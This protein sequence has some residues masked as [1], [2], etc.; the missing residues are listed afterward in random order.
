MQS[1]SYRC[2]GCQDIIGSILA[3]LPTASRSKFE[4][5]PHLI[6]AST[7]YSSP[8]GLRFMDHLESYLK[9]LSLLLVFSSLPSRHAFQTMIQ[10]AYRESNEKVLLPLLDAFSFY[11]C[12][13]DDLQPEII[14][15]HA[16]AFTEH[17]ESALKMELCYACGLADGEDS[18]GQCP[19][20]GSRTNNMSSYVL[21]SI[22]CEGIRYHV[23]SELYLGRSL[24]EAGFHL[25]Q[26]K[27]PEGERSASLTFTAFGSRI[28]VDA[29]GVGHPACVVLACVTTSDVSQSKV[30][31]VK[32][33]LTSL[34]NLIKARHSS[35]IPVHQ[36]LVTTANLDQNIDV[37]GM[38]KSGIT[39]LDHEKLPSLKKEF[40]RLPSRLTP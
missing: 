36:V 5:N 11:Y 23:P 29:I 26:A 19:D 34:G 20:C 15:Y 40:A 27:T 8:E 35:P 32:G 37:V 3:L 7:F 21:P 4:I 38:E 28:D 17:M 6:T 12:G 13:S 30:M 25:V 18:K 31:T 16:R 39:L 22:V 14:D 33:S 10:K 1:S 2:D 24:K 9:R